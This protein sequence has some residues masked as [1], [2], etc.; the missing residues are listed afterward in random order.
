[1]DRLIYNYFSDDDFLRI[2]GKIKEMEK[3]TSGEIRISIK[4]KKN[5]SERKI[6][7]RALAEM[8]FHKLNMHNTRDKT[9]ILLFLLLGEKKFYILADSGIDQ[10]VG[11][12]VWDNVRDEIQ[13]HF[14]NGKF[15]DGLIW[16]IERVGEILSAHFPI[17]SDDT[18]ELSNEIVLG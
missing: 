7:M 4:E 16:G 9:G 12:S 14:Q 2:S 17:K 11:Q 1:M 13:N 5:F 15:G 3:N 8:E 6:D 10:K 18:N